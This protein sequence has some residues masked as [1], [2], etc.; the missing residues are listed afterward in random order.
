MLN[1]PDCLAILIGT[2]VGIHRCLQ[3]E[4]YDRPGRR[5]AEQLDQALTFAVGQCR[6]K[7]QL[8]GHLLVIADQRPVVHTK[9]RIR[10]LQVVQRLAWQNLQMS[11][12]VIAEVTDQTAGERQIMRNSR[13]TE[14]RQIIA[15]ALQEIAAIFVGRNREL[16]QRPRAEQV[17]A[18]AVGIGA[19][20]V[21]QH[22]ARGMMNGRE[23]LGGIGA[24]G[25]RVYGA[26]QHG[27]V[28][29][30]IEAGWR[31]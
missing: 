29:S 10:Q 16:F 2:Q 25:Q 5:L 15:K 27:R 19:A 22:G 4:R 28:G 30:A 3:F 23:V 21:E 11:A 13:F 8:A 9:T 14:S 6:V 7:H 18:P 12:E 20:A 1:P 24:I 31:L 26:G 17:V